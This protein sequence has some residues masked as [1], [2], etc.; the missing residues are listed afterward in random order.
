MRE[1]RRPER[2]TRIR[3]MSAKGAKLGKESR[4]GMFGEH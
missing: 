2:E 3:A 1:K 4:D